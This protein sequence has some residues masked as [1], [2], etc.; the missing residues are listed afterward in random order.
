M[1]RGCE[2]GWR[3]VLVAVRSVNVEVAKNDSADEICLWLEGCVRPRPLSGRVMELREE[4]DMVEHTGDGW[5]GA[6]V[7]GRGGLCAFTPESMLGH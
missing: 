5:E 4:R 6:M 2:S 3:R 7:E 1:E